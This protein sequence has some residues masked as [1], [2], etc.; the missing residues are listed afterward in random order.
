ML[1]CCVKLKWNDD[2]AAP[3]QLKKHC[4]ISITYYML[5]LCPTRLDSL[6]SIFHLSAPYSLSVLRKK[7][8]RQLLRK[9]LMQCDQVIE[10]TSS[11]FISLC[12]YQ[13]APA[14]RWFYE[15]YTVRQQAASQTSKPDRPNT[16]LPGSATGST[17]LSPWRWASSCNICKICYFDY[18]PLTASRPC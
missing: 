7:S 8:A 18:L 3:A 11:L 16:P 2:W 12:T 5:P 14:V 4:T 13:R 9:L 1:R 15:Q 6:F 10:L 17:V